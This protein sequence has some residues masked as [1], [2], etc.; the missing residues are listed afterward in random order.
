[1]IARIGRPTVLVPS[2]TKGPVDDGR[3]LGGTRHRGV[4][5]GVSPLSAAAHPAERLPAAPNSNYSPRLAIIDEPG[6]LVERLNALHTSE[7]KY[8]RSGNH[9]R[10]MPGPDRAPPHR[11]GSS[12]AGLTAHS[13]TGV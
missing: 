1:V 3:P 10:T 7:A 11:R 2:S 9:S 5:A 6:D 13:P 12:S 8:I 4:T